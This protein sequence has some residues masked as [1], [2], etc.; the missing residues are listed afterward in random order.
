MDSQLEKTKVIL[1]KTFCFMQW[2]SESATK[3][4]EQV[5]EKEDI[6]YLLSLN[7]ITKGEILSLDGTENGFFSGMKKYQPNELFEI[8]NKAKKKGFSGISII[9]KDVTNSEYQ[10]IKEMGGYVDFTGY[11]ST[12]ICNV[13]FTEEAFIRS[14]ISKI[15]NLF[16]CLTSFRE[17]FN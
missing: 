8:I 5:M 4:G 6:E 16:G 10:K 7:G 1:N 17:F 2:Q 15:K 9:E 12:N 3:R 14:K 13:Y 11:S